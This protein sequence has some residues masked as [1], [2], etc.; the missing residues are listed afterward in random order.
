MKIVK[1]NKLHSSGLYGRTARDVNSRRDYMLISKDL[2]E[3][4]EIEENDF[5]WDP[6]KWYKSVISYVKWFRKNKPGSCDDISFIECWHGDQYYGMIA[7]SDNMIQWLV[8]STAPAMYTKY[9]SKR[10]LSKK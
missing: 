1:R 6:A 4:W 3:V 2:G 8:H 9:G 10:R 7:V 5:R